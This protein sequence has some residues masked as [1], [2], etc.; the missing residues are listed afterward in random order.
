[1]DSFSFSSSPFTLSNGN[2]N[3]GI[4]PL[5]SNKHIINDSKDT[6][7]NLLNSNVGKSV[8]NSY[9]GHSIHAYPKANS[10]EK[11]NVGMKE[12]P[13]YSYATIITYAIN[14]SKK[15]RLTLSELYEWILEN[16]PYFKTA[17]TGW[18]NSV[19]HN[20]SLNKTFTKVPRPINESGKGC[21]WTVNNNFNSN[22]QN[23]FGSKELG[24]FT[25]T[26]RSSSL[27]TSNMHDN[28]A[29]QYLRQSDSSPNRMNKSFIAYNNDGLSM[30]DS[31]IKMDTV[32]SSSSNGPF[33]RRRMTNNSN[34]MFRLSPPSTVVG[35]DQEI[36][37]QSIMMIDESLSSLESPKT[38]NSTNNSQIST[39]RFTANNNGINNQRRSVT[40]PLTPE[41]KDNSHY[42]M[43]EHNL[44]NSNQVGHSVDSSFAISNDLI[45]MQHYK[46]NSA[47]KYH[48][49]TH[50]NRNY[51]KSAP[52]SPNLQEVRCSVYSHQISY[53][54]EISNIR[55]N[56]FSDPTNDLI[57]YHKRLSLNELSLKSRDTSQHVSDDML[58]SSMTNNS[59]HSIEENDFLI[60]LNLGQNSIYN[61]NFGQLYICNDNNVMQ[62]STGVLPTP[63]SPEVNIGSNGTP[64]EFFSTPNN[65]ISMPKRRES[66]QIATP[67]SPPAMSYGYF[68]NIQSNN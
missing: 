47:D 19:R 25:R 1:M 39:P 56:L 68:D 45:D 35:E 31:S 4:D 41:L 16:F 28:L 49:Q 30:L 53:N 40:I 29:Y 60:P 42:I 2:D 20:L 57:D 48:Y 27:P 55:K 63:I 22:Q 12:K 67:I 50:L 3:S 10:F 21:Y 14:T 64:Y 44:I 54:D 43:F 18:K 32:D 9:S 15:N 65:I 8:M 46:H 58:T 17:G 23:N 13:P 61:S 11:I 66:L 6:E 33:T 52:E 26:N 62:Y 7:T 59:S 34:V 24:F 36:I 51:I 38:P 37:P 5:P